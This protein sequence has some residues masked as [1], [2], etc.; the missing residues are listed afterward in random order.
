M[1]FVI[2]DAARVQLLKKRAAKKDPVNGQDHDLH[3][4][5]GATSEEA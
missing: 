4:K 3:A 1:N 5:M 2:H